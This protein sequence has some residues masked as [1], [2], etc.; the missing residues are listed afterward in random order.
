MFFLFKNTFNKE[1][2]KYYLTY[3]LFYDN[4]FYLAALTEAFRGF[5]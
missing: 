3:L 2:Y 1:K 5:P 4:I